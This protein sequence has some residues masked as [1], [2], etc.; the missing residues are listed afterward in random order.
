MEELVKQA[1]AMPATVQIGKSGLTD[2]LF[3][4]ID[5]Q[6]KKREIIKV[7]YLKSFIYD[8]NRH[9]ITQEIVTRTKSTLI[10]AKGFTITLYRSS[11][12]RTQTHH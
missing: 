4:E 8:K 3:A 5:K 10:E 1:Q 7:R 2:S 12:K 11:P 9:D 6:L